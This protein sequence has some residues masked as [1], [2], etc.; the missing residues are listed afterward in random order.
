MTLLKK[1][2][3]ETHEIH[4]KDKEDEEFT[5]SSTSGYCSNP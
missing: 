2:D 1:R 4:E 3:H 5:N